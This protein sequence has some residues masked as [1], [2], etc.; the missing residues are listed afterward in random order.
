[1]RK[2]IE[3]PVLS[4]DSEIAAFPTLPAGVTSFA[5]L[6]VVVPASLVSIVFA[7]P[8]LFDPA[9]DEA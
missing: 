7:L 6:G 5:E 8:N 2:S 3:I 1:M 9:I 4:A